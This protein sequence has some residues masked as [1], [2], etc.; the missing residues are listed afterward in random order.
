M[1]K[2]NVQKE[3]VVVILGVFIILIVL[4]LEII[5]PVFIIT[6]TL[7]CGVYNGFV[8]ML[9][10]EEYY[11]VCLE[12]FNGQLPSQDSKDYRRL[13]LDMEL[14]YTSLLTMESMQIYI[15]DIDCENKKNVVMLHDGKFCD[16]SGEETRLERNDI[17][18]V[19]ALVYVGDLN[20]EKEIKN[21][22]EDIAKH[23]TFEVMYNMQ[24]FGNRT[25]T[26]KKRGTIKNYMISDETNGGKRRF[27]E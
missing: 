7:D 2:N 8:S 1:E 10:N 9:Q 27:D 17:V 18:S 13:T 21:R 6:D 15:K 26:W 5:H 16:G 24:W 23:T 3:K 14:L 20:T 19:F 11:D 22:L 4:F 25:Y 12:G